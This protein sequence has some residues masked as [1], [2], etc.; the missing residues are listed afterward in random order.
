[1]TFASVHQLGSV[2]LLRLSCAAVAYL[3][4]DGDG[5]CVIHLIGGEAV[6]VR[7]SVEEIEAM[8]SG[9]PVTAEAPPKTEPA[10]RRKARAAAK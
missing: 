4:A 1:V 6:R 3:A 2:R 9:V 7:E 5:C 10:P 8:I